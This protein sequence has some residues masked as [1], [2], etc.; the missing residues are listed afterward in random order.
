MITDKTIVIAGPTAS[1][2][3]EIAQCIA[4]K[5]DG[6]VISA[7]SM[8]IYRGLDIGTGKV[9][10][11]EMRVVHHMLSF[12]DPNEPYSA[13]LFQVQSREK[14]SEIKQRGHVPILAGGTGFYIRA[15]IDDYDFSEGEQVENPIRSRFEEIAKFEGRDALWKMLAKR[16]EKSAAVIEK[17]DVKRVIRALEL[18]ARGES[19]FDNKEKLSDIKELIPSIWIGLAVKRDI[20]AHRISMRVDKMIED[21][22]V[23]EVKALLDQGFRDALCSAKAI[24]YKEIVQYLDGKIT[25]DE[26]TLNIKTNT[27]RYAK[28]QRTWFR[29]EKRIHWISADEFDVPYISSQAL[30]IIAKNA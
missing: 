23:D 30:D 21:G 27:R 1:G 8:Q 28:R 9:R 4:E 3:S 26:A 13:A 11:G 17:N 19:Y 5:I 25:L 2:K 22:L 10:Q 6:E 29:A 20:L 24:G 7:D 16:D 12:V 18:N 15:A 14:I